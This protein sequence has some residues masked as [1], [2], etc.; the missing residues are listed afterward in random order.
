MKPVPAD[1]HRPPPGSHGPRVRPTRFALLVLLGLA[2]PLF[3]GPVLAQ[4]PAEAVDLALVKIEEVQKS[5][6]L[7]PVELVPSIADGETWTY[8]GVSY[9]G[10]RPGVREQFKEDPG[11]YAESHRRT[12]WVNNFMTA[13]STI[14]CPI[15]DE[16]TPG[17]RKRLEAHGYVWE[18]CCSFCDEEMTAENVVDALELLKQRAEEAYDLT[19]G[20]YQNGFASPVQG[21]IRDDV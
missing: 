4:L 3:A 11:T 14:W 21:A 20:T 7:C 8:D 16:V 5:E 19:G 15:T 9:R 2:V 12:R 1:T 18:S 17:G 13:M 6:D 10:S